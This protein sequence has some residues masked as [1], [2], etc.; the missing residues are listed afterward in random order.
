MRRGPLRNMALEDKDVACQLGANWYVSSV[1]GHP[2][3]LPI[4]N[5]TT[6]HS[7]P[8]RQTMNQLEGG[9]IQLITSC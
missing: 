4:E 8:E 2:P 9:F 6:A 1:S 5:E 7:H 3:I